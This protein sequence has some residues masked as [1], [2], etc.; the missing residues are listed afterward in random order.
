MQIYIKYEPIANF[1]NIVANVPA[2]CTVAAASRWHEFLQASCGVGV[3]FS[4]QSYRVGKNHY[5]KCGG[6]DS[7]NR[8]IYTLMF[9]PLAGRQ[10]YIP[11]C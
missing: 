9:V 5:T 1:P 10:L 7:G 6:P 11:T 2:V 4:L 8:K 3:C